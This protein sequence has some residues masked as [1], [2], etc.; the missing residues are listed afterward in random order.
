M[1]IRANRGLRAVAPRA[2]MGLWLGALLSGCGGE[3]PAPTKPEQ[4]KTPPP[5]AIAPSATPAQPG[6]AAAAPAARRA[7]CA[8]KDAVFSEP[9]PDQRL[10]PDK[11]RAGKSVG[12]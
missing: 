6:T 11:T 9:P 1:A 12:K 2:L 5:A 4:S 7:P 3:T 10:P 8:F